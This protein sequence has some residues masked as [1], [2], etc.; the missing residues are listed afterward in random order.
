MPSWINRLASWINCSSSGLYSK[1]ALPSGTTTRSISQV[2]APIDG[3]STLLLLDV[4][5]RKISGQQYSFSADRSVLPLEAQGYAMSIT[6]A[7]ENAVELAASRSQIPMQYL[8]IDY[9]EVQ[10]QVLGKIMS[11]KSCEIPEMLKMYIS[12][13]QHSNKIDLINRRKF[14][15]FI[16]DFDVLLNETLNKLSHHI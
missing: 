3:N 7:F 9:V 11:D 1:P 10:K 5:V 2:S 4:I 12:K 14:E 8:S 16:A 15:K 6:E 13:V